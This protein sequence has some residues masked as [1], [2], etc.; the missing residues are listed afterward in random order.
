MEF[1]EG[2]TD[3]HTEVY[4][5]V[6]AGEGFGLQEAGEAIRIAALVRTAPLSPPRPGEKHPFL[7]ER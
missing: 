7:E 5:R 4:R 2:F 3:L 6:L 1:S